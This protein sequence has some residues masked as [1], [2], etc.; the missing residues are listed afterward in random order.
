MHERG[1]TC[2]SPT[3]FSLRVKTLAHIV[4]LT[5]L[6]GCN[7]TISGDGDQ[8]GGPAG[9]NGTGSTTGAGSGGST[10][11]TAQSGG[12]RPVSLDGKPIYSRF[13][14]LTNDQWEHS[15]TDLM[16]LAQPLGNS[17]N[18]VR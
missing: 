10:G 9:P 16:K 8:P 6:A 12:P 11:G 13:L 7:A 5:L 4:A 14:R 3:D 2:D 1:T 15:V 17:A 18:F